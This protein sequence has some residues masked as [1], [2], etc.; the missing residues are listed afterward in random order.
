MGGQ[1]R[2]RERE[3][4][5]P[6]ASETCK[7]LGVCQQEEKASAQPDMGEK[8]GKEHQHFPIVGG[9][10]ERMMC[11]DA[12]LFLNSDLEHVANKQLAPDFGVVGSGCW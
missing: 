10:R 3:R 7:D 12:G 5:R 11:G 6:M 8:I 4:Y 9:A 1:E 2:E